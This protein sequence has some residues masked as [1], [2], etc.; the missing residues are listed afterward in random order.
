MTVLHGQEDG[1]APPNAALHVHT[2]D[3]SVY[4]PTSLKLENGRLWLTDPAV[5]EVSVSVRDVAEIGK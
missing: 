2:V 4:A 5:G 3:G 1:E